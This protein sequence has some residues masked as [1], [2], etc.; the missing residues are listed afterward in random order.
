MTIN[1]LKA[2]DLAKHSNLII[3]SDGF[4]GEKDK[5]AVLEVRKLAKN[6]Q[7]FSSVR[8]IE[9][10]EN[11]GL[12]KSII[13]GVTEVLDGH[14]EVIVLE[15][16]LITSPYFLEYMNDGLK[17]Y[18]LEESV[19]SIHGYIYPIDIQLNE[20]FF[21]KGADCWGWATWKRSWEIFNPSGKELLDSLVKQDLIKEF[22]FDS[23]YLYSKMLIN[24]IENKNDSWAIRWYAST[25]LKNKFTLYPKKSLVKNIGLDGSG[26]HGNDSNL[27][28]ALLSNEKIKVERIPVVQS[29][30]G[31]ES[32]KRYF[33]RL[34]KDSGIMKLIKKSVNT[35][36]FLFILGKIKRKLSQIYYLVHKKTNNY[37]DGAYQSWDEASKN[38]I[39]YNDNEILQKTL[40]ATLAVKDGKAAYER[41]SVLFDEIEYSW[42][43]ISG[44]LLAAVKSNGKL[45]V[46]DYGGSLG[47]SYFQNKIF[48]KE[49]KEVQW[50]VIEQ[51]H[52]VEIAKKY[53]EDEELK[54]YENIT[55]LNPTNSIDVVLLSSVLPYIK[56]P[57]E[58]LDSIKALVPKVIIIDRTPF[59]LDIHEA[60]IIR[61]QHVPEEIYSAS[62]PCR[63]F[64]ESNFV[65]YFEISDYKL[66]EKFLSLDRFDVRASWKGMI[67]LKN[68]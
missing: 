28:N 41:D 8:L 53:I 22:N 42:P 5:L 29:I 47:S 10:E 2:N 7:G 21:L 38:S 45:N 39:G 31:Y 63:F 46:L 55:D 12:S 44:L 54:F 48:L 50:N 20:N 6:I 27:M 68:P 24:Q 60:D 35:L 43:L 37:C 58:V 65:K 57:Y 4:K 25:F 56:N 19:A 36:S 3:Y 32:F 23:T 66:I 59:N 26:V 67:F 40:K 1:S 52:Y 15:D 13:L 14:N 33:I 30:E 16:D 17:M 11:F 62:Y 49:L 18:S 51:A 9:R 34:N 61:I 64:N